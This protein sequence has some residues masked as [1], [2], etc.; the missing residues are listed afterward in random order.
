MRRYTG[1]LVAAA[2]VAGA[3]LALSWFGV[4]NVRHISVN[5]S[6]IAGD[7]L[8]RMNVLTEIEDRARSLR[9]MEAREALATRVEDHRRFQIG[10]DSLAAVLSTAFDELAHDPRDSVEAR[11]VA[12]LQEAWQQYRLARDSVASAATGPDSPAMTAFRAREGRFAAVSTA[13]EDVQSASSSRAA[14]LAADSRT[15]TRTVT[16]IVLTSTVLTLLMIA[17]VLAFI[18]VD[19][20]RRRAEQRWQDVATTDLGMVWETDASDRF[21]FVSEQLSRCLGRPKHEIIGR[22]TPELIVESERD[23]TAAR[24]LTVRN[25]APFT[26]FELHVARPDGRLVELTIAGVPIHD[27]AGRVS[28]YRGVAID[29]TERRQAEVAI[30][31]MQ[32]LDSLGTLAGG[33]AHDFNNVLHAIGTYADL[34][35]GSLDATHPARGDLQLIRD[36]GARGKRLVERILTFSRARPTALGPVSL[37]AIVEEA[38]ALVRPTLPSTVQ[39][40]WVQA[41]IVPLIQADATELHQVVINLMSNAI[42]A[43]RESG[44][45]LQLHAGMDVDADGSRWTTFRVTDTGVGMR[46]DVV[47]RVFEPF[48]TTKP[49]TDGTGMGLAVVHG[50]VTALGGSISVESTPGAGTTFLVRLPA[51]T[52]TVVAPPTT[53]PGDQPEASLTDRRVL[54]VD[55]DPLV[56][57]AI[58]RLLARAGVSVAAHNSPT[59]ALKAFESSPQAFDVVVSD[60][61]MPGMTGLELVSRLRRTDP[62]VPVIL[63]TGY[64]GPDGAERAQSLGVHALL[65]KPVTARELR[66]AIS[67]ALAA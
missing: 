66:S 28:G 11:L 51:A 52:E 48:Y 64:G 24:F 13:L 37:P 44:G 41:P 19:R 58:S 35:A 27:D 10:V 20:L 29:M 65:D 21:V 67:S 63:C 6:V 60:I 16:A 5:A 54:L 14:R 56:L 55:D 46:A 1:W 30:A 26:G 33:I 22:Q 36:A 47:E 59:E 32:R 8:A 61:S 34:V 42:Y 50:I 57:E 31:R 45:R 17:A 39:L 49:Q 43:M 4:R 12:T 2:A 62:R 7:W 53:E 18:R 15:V 23:A 40:D 25:G 9:Q 38:F 3:A